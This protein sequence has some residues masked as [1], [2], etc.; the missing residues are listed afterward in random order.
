MSA[1]FDF[2]TLETG[3]EADWPVKVNRPKDGGQVE[4]REF[5][6]RF[7]SPT[8]AI[9]AE[10][11]AIEDIGARLKFTLKSCMIG[12]GKSE[13]EALTPELFEALWAD[14][15]AM[16]ALVVAFGEFRTG[17]PAKN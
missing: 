13:T 8:P 16:R 5:D 14:T 17:S 12:L 6:A 7:R 4:V 15:A 9:T 11:E 1:K 3:F 2:K 10:A